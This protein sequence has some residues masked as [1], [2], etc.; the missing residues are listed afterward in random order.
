MW[1]VLKVRKIALWSLLLCFWAGLGWAAEEGFSPAERQLLVD[2]YV[3]RFDRSFLEQT[4]FDQRL[5]KVEMLV[6]RN[7]HNQETGRDYEDFKSKYSMW[8]A[9]K[10]QRKWRTTLKRASEQFGVDQE[11]VVAI[12]LV[13]TGFG[14]VMGKYPVIGTFSSILVQ[15]EQNKH[16]YPIAPDADEDQVY[17]LN[18]LEQKAAW[19]KT[20]LA[21]LLTLSQK[22]RKSPYRYKGSYA[23]A[24]GLPQFLP[25]S[26]LKWGFDSDD[27]GSVNLF[28]F[29]DAIYSTANYLKSHGWK[30]G[31]H[32]FENQRVVWHYNRSA[33]YVETVLEI[34][35]SLRKNRA[36]K[37]PQR[38]ENLALNQPDRRAERASGGKIFTDKL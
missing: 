30:E 12:L 28:Y 26:Y 24:F 23:G 33:P 38:P 20:E 8:L 15:Y 5:D 32:H 37:S 35:K 10:F 21:A 11:V 16:L 2:A 18:R 22:N 19:A 36:G 14:N 9:K 1:W 17:F 4:F 13:E 31:L 27:N 7:I 25:S 3:D 6:K 29:P 34:A